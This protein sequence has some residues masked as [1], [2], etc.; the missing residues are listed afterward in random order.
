[1]DWKKALNRLALVG[2]V[3]GVTVTTTGCWEIVLGVALVATHTSSPDPAPPPDSY[4]SSSGPYYGDDAGPSYYADADGGTYDPYGGDQAVDVTAQSLR[5]DLGAVRFDGGV[6][7]QSGYDYGDS[8][9]IEVDARDT[10]ADWRV[11]AALTIQ[12]GLGHAD[13]VPGA[14]LTFRSDS[15][16]YSGTRLYIS[17]LGCSG[18]ANGGWD[19][20]NQADQV[21]V[22]VSEGSSADY[23]QLHFVGTWNDGSTVDGTVEYRWN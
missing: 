11:M 19:F 17:L 4:T 2:L 18:P 12:G 21:T 1:M 5:G 13:L 9:S 6:W 7:M 20:D 3:A 22:E 15:P 14:V 23:R 16:D 8:A 10:A